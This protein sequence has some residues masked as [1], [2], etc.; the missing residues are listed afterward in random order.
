MI[1]RELLKLAEGAL[2]EIIMRD[3]AARARLGELE[4]RVLALDVKGLDFHLFVQALN[5]EI[6]LDTVAPAEPD[7][8]IMGTPGEFLAMLRQQRESGTVAAGQVEI[9]GDLGTAQSWQALAG[10]LELDWEEW[11]ASMVGDVAAHQMAGAFRAV[12]GWYRSIHLNLEQDISEY[13]HHRADLLPSR[14]HVEQYFSDVSEL[15][16]DI[17]R[18]AARFDRLLSQLRKSP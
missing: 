12:T 6:V 17:D 13:L 5:S 16:A 11:L 18:T 7:V 15:V 1:D 9:Q 10:G 4:G 14:Q 2:R 3:E 8:R